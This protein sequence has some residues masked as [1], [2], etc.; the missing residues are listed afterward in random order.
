MKSFVQSNLSALNSTHSLSTLSNATGGLSVL[1]ATKGWR[2]L[3]PE[4]YAAE[5]ADQAKEQRLRGALQSY[6]LQPDKRRGWELLKLL[7]GAETDLQD[8]YIYAKKQQMLYQAQAEQEAKSGGGIISDW[9][10]WLWHGMQDFMGSSNEALVEKYARLAAKC[11]RQQAELSRW[12]IALRQELLVDSTPS[13]EEIIAIDTP[14]AK[15][16]QRRLL[17]Q[18]GSLVTVKNPIPNQRIK[19]NQMYSYSLNDV[20]SGEYTVLGAVETGQSSLPGWLSLQY[21]LLGSYP[22]GCTWVTVSG[23][24][25]FVADGNALLILD[26]S[27]PSNPQL[28]GRYAGA[29]SGSAYGVAISGTTAF[30]A[31]GDS[32]LLVLDVSTPSNPRLLGSY[33]AG[34]GSWS[35]SVAVSGTIAF[36]TESSGLLIL[37]VSIPS[38]PRLLSNYPSGSQFVAVSGTTAFLADYSGLLILDV[39]TPSNPRLL[40][41]YPTGSLGSAKGVVVSGTTAFVADYTGGLLILDVST[42]SNPQLLGSYPAG[43][44][45][46]ANSVAVSGTTAFVA[47]NN[48]VLILDVSTPSNPRLLGSYACSFAGSGIAYGVAVLG[49]TA[50]VADFNAGLLILE[51]S[52]G[53]LT[54][55]PPNNFLWQSVSLTINARNFTTTLASTTFTLTI[56]LNSIAIIAGAVVGSVAGVALLAGLGFWIRRRRL[57]TIESINLDNSDDNGSIKPSPPLPD[58]IS[59]LLPDEQKKPQKLEADTIVPTILETDIVPTTSTHISTTPLPHSKT[60]PEEKSETSEPQESKMASKPRPN[61]PSQQIDDSGEIKISIKASFADLEIDY[62]HK[63]GEGAYGTVYKGV[64]KYN[65]VA[66][67][68]LH[69][70]QLS[71]AAQKELKLEAGIMATMRSDNLVELRGV[72]LEAPH[73]CLVMELMPKGSLYGVL[74]NNPELPLA[75]KYRIAL[76]VVSG[77]AQLHDMDILHRDLKSLN[78]LLDERFRAKIGDF[79]LS[80]VKSEIGNM[81]TA[82][83]AKGTLGWMAPEL[84]DDPPPPATTMADIYACGMIFWELVVK[85]YRTPFQGLALQALMI[86]KISRGINQETIPKDCPAAFTQLMRSCWQSPQERPSAKSL[87]KSM[88]DLFKTIPED[89]KLSTPSKGS[90]VEIQSLVPSYVRSEF[91]S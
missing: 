50:F 91:N 35:N 34:S 56:A 69:T 9:T 38:N 26:V 81:S 55:I 30:V 10:R 43:S 84:M 58:S 45:G 4:I 33:P 3:S 85:P 79:G 72:C 6:E 48:A 78:V 80:K 67:K 29:G 49:T 36:V 5:S 75:V 7:R 13:T 19:V 71:T 37:N 86:A 42:L 15:A 21:Q 61:S 14:T 25:A 27:T 76:D 65:P 8:N 68:E 46:A 20:F 16:A 24:T 73:Y 47:N 74:K 70:K 62:D 1:L 88:S 17:Q 63:L 53:Q 77:L 28:L 59:N 64:Y 51:L 57:A 23:T 32:G 2:D 12:T 11:Q 52:Q 90:E 18:S 31:Y 54:G 39:S 40:G 89:D 41:S 87:V 22:V 83:G 66:I 60:L 44:S 82:K